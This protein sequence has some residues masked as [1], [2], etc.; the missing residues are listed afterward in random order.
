MNR[1]TE[2][3][4]A[5]DEIVRQFGNN[6]TPVILEGIVAQALFDKGR[7]LNES[8]RLEEA[9]AVSNEIVQRF[10]DNESPEIQEVVA[11]SLFRKGGVLSEL[12]RPDEAAAYVMK[13]WVASAITNRLR[14][15]RLLLKLSITRS[16]CLLG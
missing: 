2:A 1:P 10:G 16:P 9:I 7:V 5:Y 3:I 12:N 11:H 6:N 14:F 4:A 15:K 13:L 8:S